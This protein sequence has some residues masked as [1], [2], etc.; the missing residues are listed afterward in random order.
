MDHQAPP[1]HRQD[2]LIKF[3]PRPS[4]RTDR[5]PKASITKGKTKVPEHLHSPMP[6]HL[7]SYRPCVQDGE[8][9]R[10]TA[11]LLPF[12][13]SSF[14]FRHALTSAKAKVEVPIHDA[15]V[16]HPV[17][18]LWGEAIDAV[19]VE[20]RH[21]VL[22]GCKQLSVVRRAAIT[23]K[24]RISCQPVTATHGRGKADAS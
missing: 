6:A 9:C 24:A 4:A 11:Q 23:G 10:S 5:L 21:E 8:K 20:V 1:E 19:W 2:T 14:F 12:P 18:L 22:A 16:E 7:A 15:L 17:D 13:P 3:R